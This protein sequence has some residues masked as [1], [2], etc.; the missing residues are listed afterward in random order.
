[1][2]TVKVYPVGKNFLANVWEVPEYG[3]PMVLC[4]VLK[5]TGLAFDTYEEALQAGEDRIKACLA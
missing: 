5:T 3:T 4:T 1:M 2:L